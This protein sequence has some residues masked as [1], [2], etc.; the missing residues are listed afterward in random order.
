MKVLIPLLATV[1]FFSGCTT[2]GG[3]GYTIT[4]FKPVLTEDK[5]ALRT[6]FVGKWLSKQPTKEGGTRE[7]LIERFDDGKYLVEF[8]VYD[9]KGALTKTQKEFGVWGVSGGIYFTVYRGL[10]ENGQL[11][12]SD[13]TDAYNYD[14]YKI[15]EVSSEQLEYISLSSE[16]RFV[17]LRVE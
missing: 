9:A 7:A 10:V 16:G 3:S 1:I 6:S 12:P 5:K 2:A 13:P 11:Y 14:S 17:Y 4:A 15:L 8:K